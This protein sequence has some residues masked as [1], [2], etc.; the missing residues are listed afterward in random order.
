M[1]CEIEDYKFGI[2]SME[3]FGMLFKRISNLEHSTV[4]DTEQIDFGGKKHKYY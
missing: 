3:V 2:F 4:V 1:T